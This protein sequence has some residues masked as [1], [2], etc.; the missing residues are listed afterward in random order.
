MTKR[1]KSG[2]PDNNHIMTEPLPT[3]SLLIASSF[4]SR[5]RN[6]VS[7]EFFLLRGAPL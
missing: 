5:F 1:R 6:S 4:V 2:L 3:I 7:A